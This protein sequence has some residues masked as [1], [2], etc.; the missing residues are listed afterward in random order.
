MGIISW[1]IIGG[2]AGWIAS[3][4]TGNNRKMGVGSNILVGVVGGV[5]GGIIMNVIGGTG[6][7]GF[8]LWSLV[9]SI[10]GSVLLLLIINAFVKD[11]TD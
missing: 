8:N 2:I 10:V 7:T 5:I 6:I 1:I 4:I 3:M 11:K 9:V